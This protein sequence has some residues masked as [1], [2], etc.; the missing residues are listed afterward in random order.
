VTDAVFTTRSTT[1]A[2]DPDAELLSLI[3]EWRQVMKRG[4]DLYDEAQ[5]RR[6]EIYD[7]L[8][9]ARVGIGRIVFEDGTDLLIEATCEEE[10]SDDFVFRRAL[11]D[12]FR[13][14]IPCKTLPPPL[15]ERRDELIAE[16]RAKRGAIKEAK[17]AAQIDELDRPTTE[18]WHDQAPPLFD[19]IKE[20]Q[21]T[22]LR[23]AIAVL[24][25]LADTDDL[26]DPELLGAALVALRAIAEREA[27]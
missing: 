21:P 16:L 1:P 17:A 14:Q 13:R 27:L 11:H 22:T 19:R 26:D 10:I 4:D 5:R 3:A 9:P 15:K 23:G 2:I 20:M 24:E 25:V 6:D 18:I 12:T 7:K 8:P